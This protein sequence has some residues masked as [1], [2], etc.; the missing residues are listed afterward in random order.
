VPHLIIRGISVEQVK[1]IS[2]PLV[3]EL[4]E[5]CT[6]GTDNFTLEI[7]QSSFVFN[8]NQVPGYPFIEVKW[9]E[10][11]QEIR[12]QFAHIVTKYVQSF[13]IPE[14]EVAFSTFS[15]AAFYS[16]GKSYATV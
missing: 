15:E 2:T 12:D 16:N 5:L 9:L 8:Q 7:L 6:C 10:R 3:L 4:A 1:T 13:G 11:G 14:I